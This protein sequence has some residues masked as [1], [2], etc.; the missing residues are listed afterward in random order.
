MKQ[1]LLFVCALVISGL[2][3][4]SGQEIEFRNISPDVEEA[5]LELGYRSVKADI[6]NL[7]MGSLTIQGERTANNLAPGHESRFCWVDECYDPS[8]SLSDTY[9]MSAGEL[10]TGFSVQMDPMGF[11]G[12]SS[13]TMEIFVVGEGNSLTQTWTASYVEGTSRNGLLEKVKLSI[14]NHQPGASVWHVRY[15]V[16]D[17]QPG[18][19]LVLTDLEGRT[20][21]EQVLHTPQG[22]ISIPTA[23]LASGV[24]GLLVAENQRIVLEQKLV[25]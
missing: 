11:P 18:T 12:T 4:A 14:A 10:F 23:Q 16:A 17:F 6:K 1:T 2:Q 15:Q 22:E 19:R 9:V 8:R 20:V 13:I 24:Y 5:P 25:K 21:W 7:T 3:M